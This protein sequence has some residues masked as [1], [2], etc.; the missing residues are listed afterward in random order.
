MGLL[1]HVLPSNR[2]THD[3]REWEEKFFTATSIFPA[4]LQ[5]RR[6]EAVVNER[7]A[8]LSLKITQQPGFTAGIHFRPNCKAARHNYLY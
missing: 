1:P 8:C 3:L 5:F 2:H 7:A 6:G 4:P